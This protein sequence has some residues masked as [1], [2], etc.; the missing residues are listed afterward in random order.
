MFTTFQISRW[1]CLQCETN[2]SYGYDLV[3][4]LTHDR[5]WFRRFI[6]LLPPVFDAADKPRLCQ[7]EQRH[8]R[9][10]RAN[11]I[12]RRRLLRR[13]FVQELAQ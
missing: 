5:L 11:H 12:Q 9:Q 7:H 13:R 1:I 3:R 2:L 4:L 10:E 8:I 6:P